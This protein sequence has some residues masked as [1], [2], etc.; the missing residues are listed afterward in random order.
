MRS[1]TVG[2]LGSALG[3]LLIR[4]RSSAQPAPEHSH[5][6]PRQTLFTARASGEQVVPRLGHRS[7][8]N[9]IGA[10]VISADAKSVAYR[11]T[12][13]RL[14]SGPV[15][16]IGVR[17]FGRGAVGRRIETLCGGSAARCPDARGGT[18]EGVWKIDA[19]L[20]RELGVERMYFDVR[21]A[22]AT[23]GEL[24]GQIL[25]LPWM[26]H[27]EQ[28]LGRLRR[29]T[30]DAP[31]NGTATFYI[32]PLPQGTQVQFDLTVAGLP[33]GDVRVEIRRGDTRALAGTLRVDGETIYRRGGTIFGILRA[34]DRRVPLSESVVSAIRSGRAVLSVVV[35]RRT[36]SSGTLVPV[37]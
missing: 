1:R 18:I 21:T 3:F 10:F 8:A 14:S 19:L 11:V 7:D 2:T 37:M 13:D 28:F 25:P 4:A 26:I 36:V 16:E 34:S 15:T 20:A 6:M 32:T 31:G 5:L 29:G 33:D 35:Q 27:S 12:W 24:R 22:D 9:G 17:N 23:E 30:A